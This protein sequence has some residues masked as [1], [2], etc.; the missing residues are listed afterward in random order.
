MNEPPVPALW[1]PSSQRNWLDTVHDQPVRIFPFKHID[2]GTTLNDARQGQRYSE[3]F[4]ADDRHQGAPV[5]NDHLS[6]A[7]ISSPG[8]VQGSMSATDERASSG[9]VSTRLFV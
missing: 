5:H 2:H 9:E 1:A 6:C 7:M 4:E 8:T 3:C